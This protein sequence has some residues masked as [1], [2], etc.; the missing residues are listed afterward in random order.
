MLLYSIIRIRRDTAG[1]V[2]KVYLA[3][4]NN[5]IAQ[6][7]TLLVQ[8]LVWVLSE[9]RQAPVDEGLIKDVM[10]VTC[11]SIPRQSKE[12]LFS[13]VLRTAQGLWPVA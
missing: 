4:R 10:E 11:H 8:E 13:I 12:Y 3:G 1:R 9:R 2:A 6:V 7:Y 5:D